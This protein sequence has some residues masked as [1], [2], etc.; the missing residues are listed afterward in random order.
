MKENQ[1]KYLLPV[2]TSPMLKLLIFIS[3][4]VLLKFILLGLQKHYF[5]NSSQS[6][7]NIF[8]FIQIFFILLSVLSLSL[9]QKALQY[10]LLTL[11]LGFTLPSNLPENKTYFFETR[12]SYF[13]GKIVKILSK[14]QDNSH[15]TFICEG[16]IRSPFLPDHRSRVLLQVFNTKDTNYQK[17]Y[18]FNKIKI[19]DIISATVKLN[20]PQKKQF[21][22][23][24][25]QVTFCSSENIHWILHANSKDFVITESTAPNLQNKFYSNISE[26]IN[27]LFPEKTTN[28]FVF[29]FLLADKTKLDYNT[30][31]IF[32]KNGTAHLF[33]ISGLHVG[34]FSFFILFLTTLVTNRSIK[35]LLISLV[36]ITYIYLIFLP[37]SAVRATSLIVLYL[38]TKQKNLKTNPVNL[39]SLFIIIILLI[40]PDI[41]KHI[42][43]QLSICAYLSIILF[44]PRIKVY[45]TK[46][47]K[48]EKLFLTYVI[49]SIGI[50][51]VV[52]TL[53]SP[54]LAYYFNFF[55]LISLLSNLLTVGILS[56][57]VFFAF[58][59]ITLSFIYFPFAVFFAKSL[60][61]IVDLSILLNQMIY[62]NDFLLLTGP[63]S[64][65]FA[66]TF[67][68][69]GIIFLIS[70]NF[71]QLLLRVAYTPCFLLLFYNCN[72]IDFIK[73][74]KTTYYLQQHN[75]ISF[76]KKIGT[77]ENLNYHII[78]QKKFYSY[79]IRN[80]SL[81][82]HI[83]NQPGKH[84]II[85]N[86]DIGWEII[87]DLKAQNLFVLPIRFSLAEIERLNQ[88]LQIPKTFYNQIAKD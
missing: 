62:N 74:N 55:S 26:K 59:T 43:M 85:Y 17:K 81:L 24:F 61:P 4:G 31:E 70:K 9:K 67:S 37:D 1:H 39:L 48:K 20:T 57:A 14:A 60:T 52:T 63:N 76:T 3:L 83:K 78:E 35:Y 79:Y 36:L 66:L 54:I 2:K 29:A 75:I 69:I 23:E 25:D 18:T 50:T 41:L 45:S 28:A 11:L 49:Q 13:S 68:F 10:L 53:L 51:F 82:E 27:I 30:K 5:P 34:I 44:S 88:T 58:F 12:N 72:V 65:I 6:F 77:K 16:K 7:F 33:A 86:G 15:L 8:T 32:S 19:G 71:K 80:Y 56:L 38:Y 87:K 47:L 84:I 46:Y 64:L 40:F 73:Q 22:N 42:G 21:E